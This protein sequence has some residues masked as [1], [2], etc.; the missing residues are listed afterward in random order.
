MPS[1]TTDVLTA[2]FPDKLTLTFRRG[3]P[4]V[5]VPGEDLLEVAGFIRDT[6]QLNHLANISCVDYDEEFEMAYHFHSFQTA[7]KLQVAVRIPRGQAA[8]PS[9]FSLYPTADWQE[10]EIFDLMGITFSD[11]PNL[12]RILMPDDYPGYPLRKDFKR[13]R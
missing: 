8:A 10:R 2:A 3:Y 13:V 7:D 4:S 12:K 1:Q 9:L 6:L 5:Q 11:H